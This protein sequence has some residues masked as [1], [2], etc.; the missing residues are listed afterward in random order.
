MNDSPPS[1]S[2]VPTIGASVVPSDMTLIEFRKLFDIFKIN[3]DT[4]RRYRPGAYQGRITLFCGDEEVG[5]LE[6]LKGWEEFATEGVDVH[7]VPGDH[8]SMIR[9]P[10]VRALGAQLSKCI[11]QAVRAPGNGSTR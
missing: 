3:A 10:N 1:S 7:I 9:E 8:F 4:L 6:P 5:D 11:E 2:N